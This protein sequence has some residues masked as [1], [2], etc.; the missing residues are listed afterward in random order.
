MSRSGR[1]CNAGRRVP[2][3]SPQTR[4]ATGAHRT[5]GPPADRCAG[6]ASRS[7]RHTQAVR[8][9]EAALERLRGRG[10][11]P[12]DPDGRRTSGAETP[13]RRRVDGGVLTR[14]KR[15]SPQRPPSMVDGGSAATGAGR[16]ARRRLRGRARCGNGLVRSTSRASPRSA[17]GT[18]ATPSGR[19]YAS[20]PVVMMAAS[21]GSSPR[22]SRSRVRRRVSSSFA[23]RASL[24]SS[25]TTRPSSRSMLR[26]TSRFPL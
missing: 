10:R 25:A 20:G 24:I 22:W 18:T 7:R 17:A 2:R 4:S 5:G 13:G 23:V 11:L 16:P 6:P 26:S 21:K 14:R 1:P 15:W 19:R 3:G 9:C 12:L 8:V